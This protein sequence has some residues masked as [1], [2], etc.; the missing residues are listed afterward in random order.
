MHNPRPAQLSPRV[1]PA[2]LSP[3][4]PKPS[5]SQ[6]Q[7]KPSPARR[8]RGRLGFYTCK[9]GPA[10]SPAQDIHAKP[11]AFLTRVKS[12][13]GVSQGRGGT[14]KSRPRGRLGWAKQ[15]LLV[16]VAMAIVVAITMALVK[17]APTLVA[18]SVVVRASPRKL[19]PKLHVFIHQRYGCGVS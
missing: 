17:V 4:Q 9:I 1:S 16:I 2:Q 14:K 6:A 15:L 3:A 13:L 11:K 18:L 19:V 8:L 10:R 7:A 12:A 5:P